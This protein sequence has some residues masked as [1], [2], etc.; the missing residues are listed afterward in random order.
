ML[1]GFYIKAVEA[2]LI[3][4]ITAADYRY[5][6]TGNCGFKESGDKVTSVFCLY[7]SEN[8]EAEGVEENTVRS[9]GSAQRLHVGWILEP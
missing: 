1:G 9:I 4:T 8:H 3:W 2:N 7:L 6:R 5:G